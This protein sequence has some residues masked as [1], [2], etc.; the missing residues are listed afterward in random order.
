MTET[1]LKELYETEGPIE[2]GLLQSFLA[3]GAAQVPGLIEVLRD[4]EILFSPSPRGWIAINA[5]HILGEMG[6]TEAIPS[7]IEILSVAQEHD[8]MGGQVVMSLEKLGPAI[9]APLVA[10]FPSLDN[11][12]AREMTIEI[13]TR[14]AL[15]YRLVELDLVYDLVVRLL[16]QSV[17]PADRVLYAGYLSDLGKPEAIG[18]LTGMLAKLRISSDEYDAFLEA[19][20]RL[21]GECPEYYFDE[22]GKGYPLDEDRIPVCPVC[23]GK[24][25]FLENGDLVHRDDPHLV[26][27]EE[28]P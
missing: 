11:P 3:Q 8:R 21:G 6:A 1:L 15:E 20:E 22:D 23:R 26:H 10:H 2:K 25:G 13:L 28:E 9:V 5:V 12:W 14:L 19:I 24:M 7:L 17:H 18:V 16:M 4:K 27:Q